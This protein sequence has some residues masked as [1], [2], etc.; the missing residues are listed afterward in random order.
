MPR[1]S[2]AVPDASLLDSQSGWPVVNNPKKW[3]KKKGLN[4]NH[5]KKGS[6]IKVEPIRTKRGITAIKQLLADNPRDLALFVLGI[7]TAYRANELLSLTIGQV[8][9]LRVGDTLDIYQTKTK[10]YR[11]VVLNAGTVDVLQSWVE[12]S[13]LDSSAPLFVSQKGGALTVPTVN[14]MIKSWCRAAGLPGNYGSHTLRKTWGYWQRKEN[15]TPLPLL[16][17]AFGHSTQQQTLDYLCIQSEEIAE[18]YNYEL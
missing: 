9:H 17:S 14:N 10:K 4:L 5:P 18:L 3:G 12:Q 16:M 1:N 2:T 15:N 7:N 11:R 13:G 6:R 8:S